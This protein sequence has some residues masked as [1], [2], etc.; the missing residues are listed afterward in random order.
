[1][2]F[3]N[4]EEEAW[5]REEMNIRNRGKNTKREEK[6]IPKEYQDFNNQICKDDWSR[7]L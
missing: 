3:F 1:M 4:L 2:L 6:E 7:A 5:R